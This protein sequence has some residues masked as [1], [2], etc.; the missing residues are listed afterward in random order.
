MSRCVFV[1][2]RPA[3]VLHSGATRLLNS[4]NRRSNVS[5]VHAKH[6]QEHVI[7][8]HRHCLRETVPLTARNRTM[9][10]VELASQLAPA[11]IHVHHTPACQRLA[12]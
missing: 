9:L 7:I 12:K 1:R 2:E 3:T 5:N 11:R 10:W 4:C 8:R 6:V